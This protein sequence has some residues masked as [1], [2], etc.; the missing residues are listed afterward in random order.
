MR[1]MRFVTWRAGALLLL[2][3]A[4]GL[5]GC[6]VSSTPFDPA[7]SCQ[8]VGGTYSGGMCRAGNA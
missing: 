3:L 7:M 5:G 4:V 2:L 6:G 8:A 1:R